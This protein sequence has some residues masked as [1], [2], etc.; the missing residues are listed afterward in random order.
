MKPAK[1]ML[2][3][4]LVTLILYFKR[5]QKASRKPLSLV[6][7]QCITPTPCPCLHPPPCLFLCL[8]FQ[9]ILLLLPIVFIFFCYPIL[10]SSFSP[11][12]R[13]AALLSIFIVRPGKESRREQNRMEQP[14][15]TLHSPHSESCHFSA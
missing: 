7:C 11:L 1:H 15:H 4:L 13:G 5:R 14:F 9:S 2:I 8:P 6:H 12:L 3:W 10:L